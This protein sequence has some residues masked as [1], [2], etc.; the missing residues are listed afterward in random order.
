MSPKQVVDQLLHQRLLADYS[1]RELAKRAGIHYTTLARIEV[2]L[3][4]PNLTI[5]L[6]LLSALN[7][8]PSDFFKE[9]ESRDH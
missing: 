4:N 3:N 6:K 2:G 7:I 8:Q 5:L 1:Q 9:I